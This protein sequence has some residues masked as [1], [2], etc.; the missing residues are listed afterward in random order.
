MPGSNASIYPQ[1]L[2]NTSQSTASNPN[3]A[4]NTYNAHASL[5]HFATTSITS[6][7]LLIML[8]I[9]L[10]V[11][12]YYALCLGL[13]FQ[14]A[15]RKRWPAFV[16]IYN[17]WVMFEITNFPGWI[18]ILSIVPF[19]SI[20]AIIVKLISLY[21]LTRRMSKGVVFYIFGMLIFSFVGLPILAFGKSTFNNSLSNNSGDNQDLNNNS[22]S[23]PTSQDS[24]LADPMDQTQPNPTPTYG[25]EAVAVPTPSEPISDPNAYNNDLSEP[26]PTQDSAT[27][28]NNSDTNQS[29]QPTED[30][31][32]I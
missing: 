19:I 14:K 1:T 9:V 17:L 21:R 24:P 32:S 12:L 29:S 30:D 18:S 31:Q 13:I 7:S 25:S 23:V 6:K 26:V 4:N 3:A 15:G 22:G 28:S 16:P 2:S 10:I 8:G 11:Y 27:E 5:I 20:V